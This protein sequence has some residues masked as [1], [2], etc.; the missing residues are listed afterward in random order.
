MTS[1]FFPHSNDVASP[2]SLF[3][4][5]SVAR[6]RNNFFCGHGCRTR[7]TFI[8]RKTATNRNSFSP[9]TS[10]EPYMVQGDKLI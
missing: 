10:L 8:N 7:D 1:S 4:S 2:P 9:A 6:V 5:V 3:V